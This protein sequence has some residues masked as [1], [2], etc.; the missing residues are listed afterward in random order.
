[1]GVVTG[2]VVPRTATWGAR[3]VAAAAQWE[4]ADEEAEVRWRGA[5]RARPVPHLVNQVWH[6]GYCTRMLFA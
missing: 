1:M 4:D 5:G 6:G 3:D 2:S